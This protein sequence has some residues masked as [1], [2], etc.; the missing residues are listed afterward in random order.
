MSSPAP[1]LSLR[2]H[3]REAVRAEVGRHAWDLFARQGYAA[4]TVEQVAESAGMSRRTFF[5]YFDGKDDLLLDRLTATG[6]HVAEQL[7]LLPGDLPTWEA[8]RRAMERSVV[9]Q[10]DNPVPTR[11]LLAM[12]RDESG[13]RAA[14]EE[15]RQRWLRSLVPVLTP[16]P[17]IADGLVASAVAG[18]AL[19]CLEAAQSAWIDDTDAHLGTLLDRAM[20]AVR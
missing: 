1:A 11:S 8:L 17:D 20:A 3:A 5:R 10:Q 6:P 15:R 13:V 12:L 19:S 14:V 18:A 7:E 9:V 4:T 2:D 16:R